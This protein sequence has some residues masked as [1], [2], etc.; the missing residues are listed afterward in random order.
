MLACVVPTRVGADA[1]RL[2]RRRGRRRWGSG[3][4]VRL[5]RWRQARGAAAR[6]TA[7]RWGR[8]AVEAAERQT[9]KR[10]LRFWCSRAR[11]SPFSLSSIVTRPVR[12]MR[13]R[14]GRPRGGGTAWDA[15][16]STAL[17]PTT[18][19]APAPPRRRRE[20]ARSVRHRLRAIDVRSPTRR[21]RVSQQYVSP[22]LLSSQPSTR[23]R[24]P[25]SWPQ[26]YSFQLAP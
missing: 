23:P 9:I 22:P 11:C 26:N 13:R 3:S 5:L 21:R 12:S 16:G 18:T 17:C 24:R 1:R 7:A 15:S 14:A 19:F 10:R 8:G 4:R 2:L 20:Q 25:S 6:V